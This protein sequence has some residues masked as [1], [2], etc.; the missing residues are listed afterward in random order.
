MVHLVIEEW[1]KKTHYCDSYFTNIDS[2]LLYYL[3]SKK[4]K[5]NVLGNLLC[6]F[7]LQLVMED[8]LKKTICF[9]CSTNIDSFELHYW[10]KIKSRHYML[11]NAL[12]FLGSILKLRI[13]L[14]RHTVF[15]VSQRCI[16]FCCII[17]QVK[18]IDTLW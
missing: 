15:A 2:V 10:T 13:G 18:R 8:W 9:S 1:L 3:I 4:I 6:S 5:I 14:N 7:S 12:S 11:A 17:W 16:P